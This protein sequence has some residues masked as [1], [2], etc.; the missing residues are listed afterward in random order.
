MRK[1][2]I[3]VPLLIITGIL[4]SSCSIGMANGS[5]LTG[6]WELW[7][8]NS[9]EYFVF[10][11]DGTGYYSQLK[12]QWHHRDFNYD[13]T[14]SSALRTLKMEGEIDRQYNYY[15]DSSKAYLYLKQPGDAVFLCFV[16]TKKL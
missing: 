12:G 14:R 11:K 5:D 1:I 16:L 2:R 4:F 6:K 8:S 9:S 10:Y 15:F 13:I 3:F 7:G